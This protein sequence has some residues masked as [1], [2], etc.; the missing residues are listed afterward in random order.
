MAS[1]RVWR[2]ELGFGVFGCGEGSIRGKNW[3]AGLGLRL[4]KMDLV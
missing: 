2:G 4:G 3:I 1:I